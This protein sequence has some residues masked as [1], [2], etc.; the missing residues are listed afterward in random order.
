MSTSSRAQFFVF[1]TCRPQPLQPSPSFLVIFFPSSDRRLKA[2]KH[3][4]I[5]RPPSQKCAG[6]F[7]SILKLVVV[8]TR[9]QRICVR[10]AIGEGSSTGLGYNKNTLTSSKL[11]R[12]VSQQQLLQRIGAALRERLFLDFNVHAHDRYSFRSRARDVV[13]GVRQKRDQGLQRQMVRTTLS[14]Q[15]SITMP[16]RMHQPQTP[17]PAARQPAA[18]ASCTP[19]GWW[20]GTQFVHTQKVHQHQRPRVVCERILAAAPA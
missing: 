13:A 14:C 2:T 9:F 6:S 17:S 19:T 15:M 18:P 4:A 11:N 12:R 7:R 10:N 1:K 3:S 20:R 16:R 8:A 5:S